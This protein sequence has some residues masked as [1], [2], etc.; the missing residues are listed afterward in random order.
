[1]YGVQTLDDGEAVLRALDRGE[2][3]RAVVVGGGHIGVETAE[4]MPRHGLETTLVDRD[5][6][7]MST[8]Q[9]VGREGAAKRVDV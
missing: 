2:V 5:E 4:A 7:P 9:I 6:Q 1:V 3:R 8:L